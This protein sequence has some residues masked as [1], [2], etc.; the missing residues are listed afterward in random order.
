RGGTFPFSYPADCY[1]V[2]RK[3]VRLEVSRLHAIFPFPRAHAVDLAKRRD[4]EPGVESAVAA[5]Q[6][7][8]GPPG[9]RGTRAF[10]RTCALPPPCQPRRSI[11]GLN[12]ASYRIVRQFS[13]VV[14][15]GGW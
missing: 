11:D 8:A 3:K 13:G 15:S 6:P 2:P 4:S 7:A 14:V 5:F 9:T 12:A 10:S 1:S